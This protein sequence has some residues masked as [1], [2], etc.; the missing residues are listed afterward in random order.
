MQKR[1]HE[2]ERDQEG[3]YRNVWGRKQKEE[4]QLYYDF[5]NEL[6]QKNSWA[7]LLFLNG[8]VFMMYQKSYFSNKFSNDVHSTFTI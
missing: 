8:L 4:M 5:K 7:Y 1:G 2:F 3:V 6:K